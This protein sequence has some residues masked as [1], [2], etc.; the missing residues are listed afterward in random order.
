MH[1]FAK[2]Q[3]EFRVIPLCGTV[4]TSLQFTVNYT[5]LQKRPF[6]LRQT[7][8]YCRNVPSIYGR[9]VETSLQFTPPRRLR[10]CKYARTQI[11]HL[12][13]TLC[14]VDIKIIG[15]QYAPPMKRNEPVSTRQMIAEI[16]QIKGVSIYNFES[17]PSAN[18]TR[19][20]V[21]T[22]SMKLASD[23]APNFARVVR[24]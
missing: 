5:V 17:R 15:T 14:P 23:C 10:A 22:H 20:K 12:P 13:I 24:P 2:S 7:I 16:V 3:S 19:S 1:M 4:E 11:L 18:A 6:N 9:L 21:S 8:R